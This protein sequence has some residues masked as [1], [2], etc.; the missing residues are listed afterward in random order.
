MDHDFNYQHWFNAY[1]AARASGVDEGGAI[2]IAYRAVN[3]RSEN[4]GYEIDQN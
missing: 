3:E 2:K 1:E 4:Q